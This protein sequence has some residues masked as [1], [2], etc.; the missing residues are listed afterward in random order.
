MIVLKT[1]EEHAAALKAVES[2]WTAEEGSPEAE[3]LHSLVEAIEAW[4]EEHYP[5][6]PPTPEAAAQFRREQEVDSE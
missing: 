4:E 6:D 2:L 1:E 3:E 5:I